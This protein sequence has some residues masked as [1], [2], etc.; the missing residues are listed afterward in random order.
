MAHSDSL[1]HS[2]EVRR[3]AVWGCLGGS[4]AP[5]VAEWLQVSVRSVRRWLAIV[6][7]EG[8]DALEADASPGRPPKLSPPQI[9][10]V[11]EYLQQ[12]PQAFDFQTSRWTAP[13]LASV[14]AE[15]MGVQFN[16]RY[17]IRWLRQQTITPQLPQ[18]V[19]REQNPV[20]VQR[21][22]EQDWPAIKRGRSASAQPLCSQMNADSSSDPYG[23]RPSRCAA[24]RRR[25]SR[26]GG[27]ARR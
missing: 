21:W 23:A 25:W 4:P 22:L 3:L 15:R 17:L 14:I 5:E 26:P 13:R 1:R 8:W 6:R 18:P 2:L 20:E 12:P 11:L 7:T 10:Q 27:R 19:A 16:P 24:R 9:A